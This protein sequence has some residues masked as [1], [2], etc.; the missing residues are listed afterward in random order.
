MFP[1]KVVDFR[2]KNTKR[3]ISPGAA[4]EMLDL[5]GKSI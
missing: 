1:K 2:K 3:K 4:E 5:L